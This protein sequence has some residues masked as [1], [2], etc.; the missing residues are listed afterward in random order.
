MSAS[1]VRE[2]PPTDPT[3]ACPIDKK[4]ILDAVKA[5]CCGKSYCEECINTHLLEND[6]ICPQCGKKVAS[7][8][9]LVLDKP[10]RTRVGDYIDK[11]MK[12]SQEAVDAAESS[13]AEGAEVRSFGEVKS[14]LRYLRSIEASK[15][16]AGASAD[17]EFTFD[18]QP[19]TGFDVSQMLSETIP[20]LQAQIAQ[21]SVMLQNPSL[22]L[23]VRQS[24]EFQ[25][26]QLQ[27]Q[28]QQAQ[29]LASFT[30]EMSAAASAVAAAQLNGDGFN[31]GFQQPGYNAQWNSAFPIQQPAGQDSA[32]QRLPVNNRR[33]VNKRERP[34]DFLEIGG[35]EMQAKM[36]KFWE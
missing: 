12:E 30:A 35:G 21:I 5:P 9:K 10:M 1:D 3:L 17:A 28:L 31:Q 22:P 13:T 6:F 29:T 14:C 25:Y 20:Q 4:L 34:S 27:M 23:Q 15:A 18:Q 32:Y 2:L 33:R 26:Q 24:T 16:G 8:D 11:M 7:L 36:P 19:G